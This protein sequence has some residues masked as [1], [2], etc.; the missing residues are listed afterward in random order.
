MDMLKRL[1]SIKLFF[2]VFI[3]AGFIQIQAQNLSSKDIVDVSAS[4]TGKSDL[5]LTVTLEIKEGWHINSNKP[6]DEFLTPT[7]ISLSDSS[8]FSNIKTEF[9]APEIVKLGFSDTELSL[10]QYQA[11]IKMILTPGKNIKTNGLKIEGSILYQPCNDKTCLFPAKKP[12]SAE[13][14]N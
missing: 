2:A 13:L 3:S 11:V 1:T 9:P 7:S 5:V 4:V 12:F 8:I 10:Y 14:K 6:L